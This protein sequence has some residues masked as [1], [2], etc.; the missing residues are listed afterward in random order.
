MTQKVHQGTD[1]Q[2]TPNYPRNLSLVATT[3]DTAYSQSYQPVLLSDSLSAW[4]QS[5]PLPLWF[6]TLPRKAIRAWCSAHCWSSSV[7]WPCDLTR[8]LYLQLGPLISSS[9]RLPLRPLWNFQRTSVAHLTLL[10][11]LSSPP[12]CICNDTLTVWGVMYYLRG[13]VSN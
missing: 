9:L 1:R 4:T 10:Q 2:K 8:N 7:A 5:C 11:P 3:V 6:H 12:P 13:A